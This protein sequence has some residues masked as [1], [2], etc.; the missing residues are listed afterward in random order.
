MYLQGGIPR[1]RVI[2]L[3]M[4][5]LLNKEHIIIR[6]ARLLTTTTKT[7]VDDDAV[8]LSELG[9]QVPA[10]STSQIADI[11]NMLQE[12]VM[13]A[14]SVPGPSSKGQAGDTK[15]SLI[16]AI[17]KSA[18]QKS[19]ASQPQDDSTLLAPL[20]QRQNTSQSS[21]NDNIH[22]L[23]ATVQKQGAEIACLTQAVQQ[24]EATCREILQL[25]VDRGQD[26][27]IMK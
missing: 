19:A 1:G 21:M 17:A 10:T 20:L 15:N 7:S 5:S 3:R 24:L 8:S 18:L 13:Q 27:I 22:E 2:T 11:R 4:L 23:V 6:D 14:E 26:R 12:M 9:G 25:V 16:A